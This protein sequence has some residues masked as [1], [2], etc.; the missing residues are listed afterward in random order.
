MFRTLKS[1]APTW[2]ATIRSESHLL[3]LMVFFVD[4]DE[5]TVVTAVVVDV[6]GAGEPPTTAVAAE[7][8]EGFELVRETAPYCAS[9]YRE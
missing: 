8:G 9:Q 3:G 6:A 2:P 1:S 4:P 5:M 7:E